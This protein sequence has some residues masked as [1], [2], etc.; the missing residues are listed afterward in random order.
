V[1][2][3][4]EEEEGDKTYRESGEKERMEREMCVCV[5][6]CVRERERG[7]RVERLGVMRQCFLF[8]QTMS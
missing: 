7:K 1:R 6:V 5:C 2:W 4:R 8:L 3:R